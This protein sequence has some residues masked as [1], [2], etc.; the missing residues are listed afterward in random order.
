MGLFRHVVLAGSMLA[1]WPSLASSADGS[2]SQIAT[3]SL[4]TTAGVVAVQPRVL[5]AV[6]QWPDADR[7]LKAMV[8]QM[9]LLA[10]PGTSPKQE[11]P[12]RVATMIKEG[13]IGGVVLFSD[14][15]ENPAQ[16]TT[17]IASLTAGS[18]R[19]RPFICVDQEGGAIKRLT[20]AEGV[21]PPA[22]RGPRRPHN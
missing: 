6:E 7:S 3:A 14:N 2:S 1:I 17:L 22:E 10:F 8:G 13:R 5:P 12:A 4:S 15:I 19:P 11:G 20:S 18:H 9:I 21:L 16:V